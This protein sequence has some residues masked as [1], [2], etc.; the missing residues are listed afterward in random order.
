MNVIFKRFG[1]RYKLT[2]LGGICVRT[3]EKYARIDREI[4]EDTIDIC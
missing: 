4:V 2:S 3:T 1:L